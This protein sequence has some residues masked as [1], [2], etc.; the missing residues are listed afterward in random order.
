MRC[1][2]NRSPRADA[3]EVFDLGAHKVINR[4]ELLQAPAEID[5]CDPEGKILVEAAAFFENVAP[6]H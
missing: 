3:A 2:P 1:G 5:V 6:D 4:P